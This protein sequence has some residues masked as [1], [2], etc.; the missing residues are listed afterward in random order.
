MRRSFW[1]LIVATMA[2]LLGGLW[3]ASRLGGRIVK[4][5][6]G[7]TGPA[8][9]LGSGAKVSVPPL[10]L[11]EADEVARAL[12]MASGL[13]HRTRRKAYHDV[14]T[15]L[16]NRALFME[17]LNQQVLLC[18]RGDLELAVL[19]L[20]LDG[21]KSINDAYGHAT[22]DELLQ[23]AASRIKGAIRTADLAARL[24]GDEFAVLL[25][26]SDIKN[27]QVVA[28]KLVEVISAPYQLH[29]VVAH[30]SA[31]IGVAMYPGSA[32][33]AGALVTR[34]D[35]AMYRAKK[36]GKACYVIAT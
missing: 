26:Q 22:G 29:H 27:A 9:A 8:L 34:A 11:K 14:L 30:V 10:H 24:G 23:A 7:L 28:A 2:L 36:S 25:V 1:L 5:I 4:A 17:I 19:Y 16:A 20:D 33:S 32:E 3:L 35:E 21:F 18:E 13:L 15:G 12:V 31:S 6:N